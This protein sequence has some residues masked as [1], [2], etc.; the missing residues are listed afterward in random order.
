MKVGEQVLEAT[1]DGTADWEG[2]ILQVQRQEM[3]EGERHNNLWL[4]KD[5]DIGTIK[6]DTVG[7]QTIS[8]NPLSIKGDYLMY[9]KSVTLTPVR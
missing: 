5:F 7:Q 1:V 2:D 6:I 3:D 8:I 4:F 9:L